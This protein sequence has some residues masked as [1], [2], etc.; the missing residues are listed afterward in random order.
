MKNRSFI[1]LLLL[2]LF[3]LMGFT[4]V[5][6]PLDGPDTRQLIGL[7]K[8]G[9]FLLLSAGDS[10]SR[11]MP[12]RKNK[13]GAYL[14]S[15][16]K[17]FRFVPDSLAEI[18]TRLSANQEL[19]ENYTLSMYESG[20]EHMIYGFTSDDISKSK[21]P[22]IGRAMPYRNYEIRVQYF[23]DTLFEKKL[24]LPLVPSLLSA[25]FIFGSVAGFG[26]YRHHQSRKNT[27]QIARTESKETP[28]V[29]IGKYV[30]D[31]H[32]Q[33]LTCGDDNIPLTPKEQTLLNIFL[34]Y[35]NQVIDRNLL[36][37]LG[38]EDE[39]VIT[40][41]SLDMYVSK[42]RK[43]FAKDES[44]DFKNVHGKGYSLSFK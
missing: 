32:E 18:V 7:R 21:V 37:K 22:C 24:S 28:T 31:L 29:A 34:K 2:S 33:S 5:A 27:G 36:L 44:V 1:Y 4:F 14:I 43:K 13:K 19:S 42:L 10:T 35:P 9:H 11:V 8:I 39:G 23:S 20:T 12:V 15:F 16:E 3:L 6:E 30:F 38:W 41:R 26:L 25:V 40:G 17:S